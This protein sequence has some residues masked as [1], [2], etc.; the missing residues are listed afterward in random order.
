MPVTIDGSNTATPGGVAYGNATNELDFSAAGTAGQ[1][2]VSNGSSP[3]GWGNVSLATGVT[4]TLPIANGGTGTT[5]TTFANLT[6]NVTGTLPVGNGGTGATTLTSNNVILGNGGSAVQFVAPGTNGNVL[7]S[8]G[9]TWTSA[10]LAVSQ[11]LVKVATFTT[12]S[13]TSTLACTNCFSATYTNYMIT[14]ADIRCTGNFTLYLDGLQSASINGSRFTGSDAASTFRGNG[15]Y[16]FL[17]PGIKLASSTYQAAGNVFLTN[18]SSSNKGSGTWM[19]GYYDV[20]NDM[21]NVSGAIINI[22]GPN[23]GFTLT[24]S[25]NFVAGGIVT[26][27][28]FK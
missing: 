10:P 26:V 24:S 20:P 18:I 19:S 4:G 27:Y 16:I 28:G 7:Q 11:D 21:A 15:Q 5:S 1:A 22:S 23:T 17:V 3:P 13:G 2:L 14:F 25:Q 8:N 9:T 6:T 12:S